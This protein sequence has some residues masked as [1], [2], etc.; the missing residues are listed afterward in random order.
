[1]AQAL[2]ICQLLRSLQISQRVRGDNALGVLAQQPCTPDAD[3][4]QDDDDNYYRDH[5]DE[6]EGFA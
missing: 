3:G 5:L 2:H 1:L 6:G 4:N